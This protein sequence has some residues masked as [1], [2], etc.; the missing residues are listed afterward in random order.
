[1]NRNT[2][3]FVVI[4][5]GNFGTSVA[6]ALHASGHEVIALDSSEAAVDRI[7]RHA[8]RAAV[9]DGRQRKTLERVGAEGADAGIVSTGD[10][11]TASILATLAL[12]D[13]NIPQ[14]YVKVISHDHARVME[15][16]GVTEWIF[17]ER[18][19]GQGLATRL[20]SAGIR[21]YIEVGEGLSVQEMEVPG[22][23]LG[24]TLRELALPRRFRISAIAIHD[25]D[26]DEMITIPD[27]DTRLQTCHALV[28]AGKEE[29]LARVARTL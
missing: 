21:R 14:V 2:K 11:I 4:G 1:M 28:L 16:I 10:D 25:K 3:R 15:K 6:E 20:G 13:M 5:L 26:R 23:W 8:T 9:G 27:P 29:D 24:H 12:R 7:A 18:E 19:S 17:P 22:S